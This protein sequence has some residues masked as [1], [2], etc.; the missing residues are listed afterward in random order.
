MHLAATVKLA[1]RSPK[2]AIQRRPEM[3]QVASAG[4]A[5]RAEPSPS[6]GCILQPWLLSRIDRQ[7]ARLGTTSRRCQTWIDLFRD[8][9]SLWCFAARECDA[10][11][12][13]NAEA[14]SRG[15][16][17][18]L[19]GHSQCSSDVEKYFRYLE[20]YASFLDEGE[21]IEL[22]RVARPAVKSV[23]GRSPA[24]K[25]QDDVVATGDSP[26]MLMQGQFFRDFMAGS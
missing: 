23:G 16:E 10:L 12:K 22:D 6:K 5:V 19:Y 14:P 4:H 17:L 20:K 18:S 24:P 21:T 9:I 25:H 3:G 1:G 7:S 8:V 15:V 13:P 2:E 11:P 26:A